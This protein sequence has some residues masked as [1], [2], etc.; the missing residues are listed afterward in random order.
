MVFEHSNTNHYVSATLNGTL[1]MCLFQNTDNVALN[2]LGVY[3][4]VKGNI[5]TRP[6][7]HWC[8]VISGRYQ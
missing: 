6:V 8:S 7:V 2:N 4:A 1:K 5:A 3:F